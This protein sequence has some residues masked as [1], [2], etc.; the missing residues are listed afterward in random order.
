MK[1]KPCKTCG[2][3]I[4]KNARF[5]PKCGHKYSHVSGCFAYVLIFI[6]VSI[7]ISYMINGLSKKSPQELNEQTLKDDLT[8]FISKFGEPDQI[9]SSENEIP[10]PPIVT[11]QLIYKKENVRAVYVSDAPVGSSPPYNK[12]KLF[13]FQDNRT[14][15]VL[16]PEEVVRRLE[17]RQKK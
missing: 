11:K 15:K 16:Q 9:K 10:R 8:I 17:K 2:Q 12:W 6:V 4:A 1:M 13:G 14:N 5:C 7:M 3:M